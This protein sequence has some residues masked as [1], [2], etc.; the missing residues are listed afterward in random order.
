MRAIPLGTMNGLSCRSRP[1][2]RMTLVCMVVLIGTARL[3]AEQPAIS[4]TQWIALFEAELAR[5]PGTAESHR[6]RTVFLEELRERGEKNASAA[7]FQTRAGRFLSQAKEKEM[8]ALHAEASSVY[9]GRHDRAEGMRLF[10]AIEALGWEL[11]ST[12]WLGIAYW[13]LGQVWGDQGELLQSTYFF[14]QSCR[15]M[16]MNGP[17]RGG[18][19]YMMQLSNLFQ[20]YRSLGL[21]GEALRLHRALENSAM[22]NLAKS[23]G[24]PVRGLLVDLTDEELKSV[25]LE[26]IGNYYAAEIS[27]RFEAG[28]DAGALAL[29]ER[30]DRRLTG[31]TIPREIRSHAKILGLMAAIHDAA[32]RDQAQEETLARMIAISGEPKAETQGFLHRGRVRLAW[33]RLRLG[34]DPAAQFAE[35]QAGLDKLAER[36][37][38]ESWLGGR[39]QFARMHAFT[40]DRETGLAIIDAAIDEARAIDTPPLLAELLVTRAELRL[41]A[42]SADGVQEDLFEAVTLHRQM[43]GLRSETAAYVQY[44]RL[45]RMTG[46]T[47]EAARML[48]EASTRL[49]RFPQAWQHVVIERESAALATMFPTISQ[50]ATINA[51]SDDVFATGTVSLPPDASPAARKPTTP[52]NPTTATPRPHDAAQS[53]L[54]PVELTT[55]VAGD[56]TARGRFTV[57]NPG[58]VT[59]SGILIARG[60]SLEAAWDAAR[61]RWDVTQKRAMGR[62]EV[63]Q[64][65]VLQP[66]DQATVFLS[67]E[68]VR[69]ATGNVQLTWEA[70]G[71]PQAAWW[72]YTH[73]GGEPDIAVVDANLAL[74]NP[75]Y[76]VPLH[77]Y[78]VR[79]AG[80]HDLPLN[81]RVTV[82]APCRVELVDAETARVIAVDATGDGDF[83]GIGDV[84]FDDRDR[85]GFP[86]ITFEPGQTARP[87]EI[88]VYPI[89]KYRS[90]D[91]N[92]DLRRPD[93]SWAP[94]SADRLIGK[95]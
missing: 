18:G 52:Q 41:D 67:T 80:R 74:E 16:D 81:L 28:D 24:E 21:L 30:L 60:T 71:E 78:V 49:R 85:D 92:L 48:A 46:R 20:N 19:G 93:G 69:D 64:L 77:H 65:V 34:A 35:A 82:S 51:A 72:R 37:S 91:V 63:R 5:R 90:V 9:H 25:P 13:K 39:G 23:T 32:G 88:Q 57:T 29:A 43:G 10:K 45:L 14:E 55:R 1:L 17:Y 79:P 53:D 15:M 66:L 42:G 36:L 8:W 94:G 68:A 56:W 73:G 86:D 62:Q 83:R 50:P 33:L 6:E 40:G 47:A 76:A 26:F 61:L 4:D 87:V 22:Q 11:Q 27:L 44:A 70:E 58:E 7:W 84:L 2:R 31:T 95:E 54:Q 12:R 59:V 3:V 89:D 38:K 75:F